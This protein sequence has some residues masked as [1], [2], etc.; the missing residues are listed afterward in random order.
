[1]VVGEHER[2]VPAHELQL[3]VGLRLCSPEVV[4]VQVEGEPVAPDVAFPAVGI[5]DRH[6]DHHSVPKDPVDDTVVTVGEV[7]EQ[8]DD[9]VGPALLV[10]VDVAGD[11]QERRGRGGEVVDA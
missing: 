4:T 5:L 11:P 7:V 3:S 2:R 10:A 9:G 1:M 6:D 8:R